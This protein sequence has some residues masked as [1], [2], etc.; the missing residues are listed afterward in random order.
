MRTHELH[1]LLAKRMAEKGYGGKEV[2]VTI[3][4]KT[5]KVTNIA[6]CLDCE[7]FHIYFE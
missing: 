4:N 1:D 6:Y 5:K 3:N 7:E 2:T